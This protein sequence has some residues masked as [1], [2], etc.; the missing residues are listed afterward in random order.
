MNAA[1]IEA[2][3]QRSF[4]SVFMSIPINFASNSEGFM[5]ELFIAKRAEAYFKKRT[6]KAKDCLRENGFLSKMPEPGGKA[7][8]YQGD[9][10]MLQASVNAPTKTL[11]KTKL[12]VELVKRFGLTMEQVAD[13]LDSCSKENKAAEKIDVI[14]YS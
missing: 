4:D 8:L 13:L 10:Y 1:M 11:D 5:H 9:V 14:P 6:D 3:L 12:S 2:N 7:I